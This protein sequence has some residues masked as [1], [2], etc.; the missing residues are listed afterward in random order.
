MLGMSAVGMFAIGMGPL[1]VTLYEPISKL[2]GASAFVHNPQ[3]V[4]T[5][6]V[7]EASEFGW[8]WDDDTSILW[9]DDTEIL[10]DE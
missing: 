10:T 4:N 5:G 2:G 7:S 3:R 9:D 8:L 6:A 1:D